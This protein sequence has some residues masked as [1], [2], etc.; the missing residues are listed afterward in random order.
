MHWGT[1][2]RKQPRTSYWHSLGGKPQSPPPR[3][4]KKK[5]GWGDLSVN[6]DNDSRYGSTEV[7][8]L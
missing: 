8:W 2:H 7:S 6:P 4:A 1:V 3:V 5:G